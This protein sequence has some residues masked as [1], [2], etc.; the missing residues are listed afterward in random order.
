MVKLT[1]GQ[2][3]DHVGIPKD[4]L[5]EVWQDLDMPAGWA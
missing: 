1:G 5:P 4:K 2:R 3:I